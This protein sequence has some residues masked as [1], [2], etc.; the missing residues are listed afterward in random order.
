MLFKFLLT[1]Y[2]TRSLPASPQSS[3][4]RSRRS[5]VR[6]GNFKPDLYKVLPATVIK[7]LLVQIEIDCVFHCIEEESCYSVNTGTVL[8]AEKI[9]FCELLA[10]DKY[11]ATEKLQANISYNHFSPWVSQMIFCTCSLLSHYQGGGTKKS[12]YALSL[13]AIHH[14]TAK[15]S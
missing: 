15:L 12:V 7:N 11:R 6:Y 2:L 9:Y 4:S 13:N 10:T 1:L 3:L 8:T 14:L 5:L